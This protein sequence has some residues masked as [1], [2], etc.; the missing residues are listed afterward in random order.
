MSSAIFFLSV[1]FFFLGL[2]A[3]DLQPL[4][5]TLVFEFNFVN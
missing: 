3:V 1:V 4:S 5:V 2:S